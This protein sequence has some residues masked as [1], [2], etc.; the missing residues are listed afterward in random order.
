MQGTIAQIVALTTYGNVFLTDASAFDIAA[1]YPGN[2]TFQFCEHVR[3]VDLKRS[4]GGWEDADYAVDPVKWFTCLRQDGVY[5][6]R[7]TY[8]S[9]NSQR[10]G[11]KKIA[12]RMLAGFVGGGGRWLIEAIKSG[13]S[14]YW[15][16]RWEIGD[17]KRKDRRIWRVKYGRIASNQASAP[18]PEIDVSALKKQLNENLEAISTFARRQNLVDFAKAF[19]AAIVEL[20]SQEP[21]KGVYHGYL[22][23][24]GALPLSANQ[25][26][27]A[28]QVAWVFGGMGSWNDQGF[29]GD[30]Q[31][32]YDQLSE[33]LYQL[34][35]TAIVTGA[36][37][38]APG[39]PTGRAKPWWKAWN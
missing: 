27:G 19:D 11:D 8:S 16:G 37:A 15:E 34:L 5:A 18:N 2:S 39:R 20:S 22:A 35:N 24:I 38:G 9:T 1:F 33:D 4:D 7:L 26:L 10:L 13:R 36:N 25:L 14:D 30:D 6:L 23:P 31:A 3:F 28:A 32:A 17:R 21:L 29:Q 12:D